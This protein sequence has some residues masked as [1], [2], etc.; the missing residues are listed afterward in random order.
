VSKFP[1]IWEM[2]TSPTP[3]EMPKKWDN[4]AQYWAT[5]GYLKIFWWLPQHYKLRQSVKA[6]RILPSH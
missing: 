1:C 3:W 4:K 2:L 6:I 5:Q